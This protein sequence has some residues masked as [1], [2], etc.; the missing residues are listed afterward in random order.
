MCILFYLKEPWVSS[1]VQMTINEWALCSGAY[2]NRSDHFGLI[3]CELIR[4]LFDGSCLKVLTFKS[5]QDLR[6]PKIPL[7]IQEQ[8]MP[9]G[10]IK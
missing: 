9:R 6:C 2:V 4:D 7:K 1:S 3:W 8:S 5:Q 10:Q